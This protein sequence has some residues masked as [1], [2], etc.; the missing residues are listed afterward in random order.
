MERTSMKRILC[1]IDFSEYSVPAYEYASSLARRYGAKLFLQF[2]VELW[3][4]PSACFAA[5]CA[6]YEQFRKSLLS[7]GDERL[8]LFVK[9]HP[10]A[11]ILPELVVEEGWAGD[12]ILS[13]ARREAV[14]LIVVGTHSA[15]GLDRVLVGSVTEAVLKKALCPVLAMYQTPQDSCRPVT[16]QRG[17]ELRE[18]LFCTDFS[19]HSNRAFDYA[20]SLAEEYHAHLTLVHVVEGLSR[21]RYSE[22]SAKAY[23]LLNKL[24]SAQSSQGQ[25]ITAVVRAGRAYK[26]ISQLVNDKHADLVI[27]AVHGNNSMDEAVFGSTTYRVVQLGSC[28]V[29]AMHPESAVGKSTEIEAM[30]NSAQ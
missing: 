9:D 7:A 21:L 14:D 4:H 3:Q 2:V 17:T 23:D 29:L 25:G 16:S 5:S 15:Q 24:I 1:P 13:F 12:S 10:A 26:E 11:G 6:E 30:S 22:R 20:V 18:I 19:D 8:R 28:P 27:M